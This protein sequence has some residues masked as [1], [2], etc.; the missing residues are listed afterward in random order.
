M[1]LSGLFARAGRAVPASAHRVI[2]AYVVLFGGL[3]ATLPYL[4]VWL[5]H[6]G[7]DG[8]SIGLILGAA[9]VCQFVVSLGAGYLADMLQAPRRVMFAFAM[10]T[11]V[12][13]VAM[14]APIAPW[15]IIVLVVGMQAAKSP[16]GPLQ[17][18][19][20]MSL[21]RREGFSYGVVRGIASIAFVVANVCVG[22]LIAP[23][24]FGPETVLWWCAGSFLAFGL[25]VR[26]MPR[27]VVGAAQDRFN[28]KAA[29][30]DLARKDV[31]LALGANGCAQASHAFYYAFSA[32]VWLSVGVS[33][34]VV[35]ALWAWG[36]MAEVMVLMVF[37]TRLERLGAGP[38]LAAGAF[39]GV[40][41]WGLAGWSPGQAFWT[42]ADR[43]HGAFDD[44]LI[45]GA[46]L[47][48]GMGAQA[49][50]LVWLFVLQTLHAGT[51][52]LA[53]LGVMVFIHDHM[54]ARVAGTAQ[55][56]SSGLSMGGGL[57]IATAMS[58]LVFPLMGGAGYLAMVPVAGLGLACA[59]GLMASL[60]TGKAGAV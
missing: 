47:G 43:V 8:P 29:W 40:V 35:G 16:L 58:G 36:V 23:S 51:F 10:V 34:A 54:P 30:Q 46:G 14:A 57:A 39:T 19:A 48:A 33:G 27:P 15:A 26:A 45:G 38:L 24:L 20:G 1:M 41:R 3:G 6:R 11:V 25:A 9:M 53:Y 22:A 18:A 12:L 49:P 32:I 50:H 52:A 42:G 5:A 44:V 31:L 28:L 7:F 60:K 4:P 17:E 37:G 21:A 56:L 55:S 2:L 13:L 59:L